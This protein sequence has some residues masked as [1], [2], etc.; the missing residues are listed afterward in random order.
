[1]EEQN[2]IEYRLTNI[3]KNLEELKN[4]IIET[5]MQARDIEEI[6]DQMSALDTKCNANERKI[7]ELELAPQKGK[8]ERYSVIADMIYKAII[9]AVIIIVL[10]KVGLK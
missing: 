9:S 1:M 3:E 5:K 10:T 6:K 7:R 2:A 8:A 4:I